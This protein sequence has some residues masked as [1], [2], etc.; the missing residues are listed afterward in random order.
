[1]PDDPHRMVCMEVWGGCDAT[2][3]AVTLSGLDAWVY[4]KPYEEAKAAE[5]SE[6]VGEAAGG[7]GGGDI[8]YVSA[9]A[10]GRINRLLVADV[11][12]H[13]AKVRDVATTLR[14]LMRRYV[15]YLDQSKFVTSMNH[16]FVECSASGC[17]ATA[18]VT[19][20]FASTRT[21]SVCN[22]G[23][24]PPLVWRAKQ[25]EWSTLVPP[26]PTSPPTAD[27]DPGRSPLAPLSNLSNLPLGIDDYDDCAQFDVELDVGDLVLVYTD[28]LIEARDKDGTMLGTSGLLTLVRHVLPD[29]D[30]ATLIP[31][32]LNAIDSRTAGGLNADD[33]TAL[34]LRAN[35]TGRG[36]ALHRSLLA[37]FKILASVGRA[38]AGKGP[39]SL[40]DWNLPNLGGSVIP[41]LGRLWAK[42][43]RSS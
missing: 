33:V 38:I 8:Y 15:N 40:P 14:D 18:I 26:A 41:A 1:M 34:L 5:A 12:G 25:R 35:G 3:A 17:F 30:P 4:S 16:Q 28:S 13:G 19:T 29:P 10:T 20:F 2:D 21:L 6:R 37:P 36:I 11:A 23:H 31:T 7:G 32:L 9:C 42:R 22:A 24:P 27:A 43:S 39:M